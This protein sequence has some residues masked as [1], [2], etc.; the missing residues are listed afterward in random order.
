MKDFDDFYMGLDAAE[1]SQILYE[2]N[3]F[4]KTIESL[5]I[6]PSSVPGGQVMAMSYSVSISLLRR[7]H[8]WLQ[9]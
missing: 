2:A 6:D 7:Y 1:I 4:S 9:Q 5:N 3:D 8:D